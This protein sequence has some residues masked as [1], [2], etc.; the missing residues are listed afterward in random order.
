MG[1][2]KEFLSYRSKI[3]KKI[4]YSFTSP[5]G[6][7]LALLLQENDVKDERGEIPQYY[8]WV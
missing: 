3:K 2:C 1:T 8:S 5:R 7:F 6:I 4:V